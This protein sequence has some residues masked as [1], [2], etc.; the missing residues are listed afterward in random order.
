L[1]IDFIDEG[2]DLMEEA[3]LN[4]FGDY[5]GSVRIPLKDILVKEN[6]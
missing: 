3:K 5:I 6:I 4:T 2:V 1:K